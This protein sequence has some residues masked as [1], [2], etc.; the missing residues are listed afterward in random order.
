MSKVTSKRTAIPTQNYFSEGIIHQ[1]HSSFEDAFHSELIFLMLSSPM[2]TF[3]AIANKLLHL[4]YNLKLF[5]RYWNENENTISKIPFYRYS[6]STHKTCGHW[7]HH[8]TLM[9]LHLPRKTEFGTRS[10]FLLLKKF[11]LSS[12]EPIILKHEIFYNAIILHPPLLWP[13]ST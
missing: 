12:S 10:Y 11:F 8:F 4:I 6:A 13:K 1:G 5:F 2:F 3:T 7:L 9:Y